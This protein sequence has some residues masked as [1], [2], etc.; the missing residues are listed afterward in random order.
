M[1][2][3]AIE[4]EEALAIEVTDT[5][6]T[7]IYQFLTEDEL[8]VDDLAA[9]QVVRKSSRYALINGWLYK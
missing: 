1:H 5:W 7:P 8:P 9:K 2:T 6:M 4:K 3:L